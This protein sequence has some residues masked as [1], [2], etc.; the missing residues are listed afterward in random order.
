VVSEFAA[1]IRDNKAPLTD[2]QAGL[3]VIKILEA[4]DK[5]IRLRGATVDLE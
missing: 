5:S 2:G 1:C 3:R 4:A